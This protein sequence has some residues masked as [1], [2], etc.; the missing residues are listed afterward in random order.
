MS[1]K[2]WSGK[3][4]S[5]RTTSAVSFTQWKYNIYSPK[6][7]T[8]RFRHSPINHSFQ[9]Y[10]LLWVSDQ[11]LQ[12]NHVT[13]SPGGSDLGNFWRYILFKNCTFPTTYPKKYLQKVVEK[14]QLCRLY[15]P[16]PQL[17]LPCLS[18]FFF[19]PSSATFLVLMESFDPLLTLAN[20]YLVL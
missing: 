3:R 4:A 15:L 17:V 14:A 11:P 6:L 1:T 7:K 18:F 16:H 10:V 20:T 5:Y 9:K 2:G 8:N 13:K 19:W 12:R